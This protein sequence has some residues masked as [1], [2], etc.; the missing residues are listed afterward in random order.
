MSKSFLNKLN[1]K[2]PNRALSTQKNRILWYP[3]PDI[4]VFAASALGLDFYYLGS[5]ILFDHFPCLKTPLDLE[6]FKFC[7]CLDPPL[8]LS[9]LDSPE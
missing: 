7:S 1:L 2:N 9:K 8:N 6:I 4:P 5:L 3:K